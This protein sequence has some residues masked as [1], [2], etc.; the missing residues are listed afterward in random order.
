MAVL[1]YWH[2]FGLSGLINRFMPL[3]AFSKLGNASLIAG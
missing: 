1:S 3:A 2:I